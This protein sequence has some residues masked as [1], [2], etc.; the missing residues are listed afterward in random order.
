MESQKLSKLCESW[1]GRLAHANRADLDT[2]AAQFLDLLGWPAAARSE[3]AN[4]GAPSGPICFTLKAAGDQ[5]IV[6]WFA[7]PGALDPPTSLVEHGLDFC[8]LTRVLA[9]ASRRRRA[10][11]AFVTDLSRSY[12]YDVETEELLLYADTPDLFNRDLAPVLSR[13]S[14]ERG[15]LED[16]RRPPRSALARQLRDWCTSWREVLVREQGVREEIAEAALDR[17]LLLRFLF[18][19]DILKRSDWR[20]R[21]RFDDLL[22]RA[23]ETSTPNCGGALTSLFHDIWFDWKAELFAPMPELDRAL[24]DDSI[25]RPM[26]REFA[27]M[28]RAKFTIGAIL[29]SFNYGDAMEK[30]RVRLVPEPDESR[31]RFLAKQTLATI[32]AARVNVDL[33]EEGYRAIFHWF[34]ELVSAYERLGVQFDAQTYDP[35]RTPSDLDLFQWSELDA[36]RPTALCDRFQHA[37]EKGLIIY[38]STP[39]QFRTGRLMLYLHLVASYRD[40]SQR[41]D[42]FPQI[43]AA[44]HERPTVLESDKKFIY[45]Q[46]AHHSAPSGP[47][48]A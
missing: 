45:Q 39:R 18:D 4:D 26:L 8:E 40:S 16:L 23:F 41:F 25:A 47:D 24:E 5:T 34:D 15:D 29:E 37:V 31:A 30:A 46:H 19:H 28:S 12:F 48:I 42:Q 17:L 9:T 21:Q 6:A 38:Y 44:F 7:M 33:A 3:S 14:I 35:L 32:D 1:W 20:L 22:T 36:T 2:Y 43:E 11:Y 10:P 27:L 13:S